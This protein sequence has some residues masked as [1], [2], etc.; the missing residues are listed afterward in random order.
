MKKT[1]FIAG[2]ILFGTGAVVLFT[3]LVMWLW[4][5]LMPAIFG[6]GII[7]FWQAAGI[8]VLSKILFSGSGHGKSW[9]ND[10]RKKYW[11]SRFKEKWEHI[12]EEKK[13]EFTEK[14]N[15]KF[16]DSSNY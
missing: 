12:P 9:H 15:E 5:W 2:A 4:N 13:R 3:F 14:M 16:G 8:L 7:T 1:K 11:H 6:L 10:R